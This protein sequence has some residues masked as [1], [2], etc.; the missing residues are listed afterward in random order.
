MRSELERREAEIAEDPDRL[1][2]LVLILA[3]GAEVLRR[4]CDLRNL[5]LLS[6]AGRADLDLEVEVLWR[7]AQADGKHAVDLVEHL[8]LLG[9]EQ[10]LVDAICCCLAEY[11]CIAVEQALELGIHLGR[12]LG[13]GGLG[14]CVLGD[15]AI[16][17]DEVHG[18][19]P[20]PAIAHAIVQDVADL[21]G[22]EGKVPRRDDA[23]EH[24]ICLLELVVEHAI[25]L[26][27][28]ER[29]DI[30]VLHRGMAGN[31]HGREHPAAA[32]LALVR[33][34]GRLRHGD[35]VR[36]MVG[37]HG[38]CIAGCLHHVRGGHRIACNAVCTALCEVG[39]FLCGP[40]RVN[41]FAHRGKTTP[42]VRKQ[43]PRAGGCRLAS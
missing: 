16:F 8:V 32:A 11:S 27:E 43:P 13:A 25:G 42:F 18:E 2:C 39:C 20:V 10:I 17:L 3:L 35:A 5:G 9:T 14:H 28:L 38:R 12:A 36:V 19:G 34:L 33:D 21:A 24:R 26:G 30:E 6:L 40:V 37:A 7:L 23:L 22:V 4:R 15:E 29:V 31:V 41:C 1:R